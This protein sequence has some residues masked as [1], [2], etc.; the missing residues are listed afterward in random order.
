MVTEID[1]FAHDSNYTVG[2]FAR[3]L[4]DLE[5]SLKSSS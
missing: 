2:S 4:R 5:I 1:N 3:L